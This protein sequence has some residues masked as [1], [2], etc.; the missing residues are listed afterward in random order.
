MNGPTFIGIG[1][2]KCASTWLA[3]CLARHPDIFVHPKKEIKYFNEK[4]QDFA[5]NTNFD[6]PAQWY[7]SHFEG[8]DRFTARGEF[9]PD[10]LTSESAPQRIHQMLGEVKILCIV[11]NPVDRLRSH[12][13]HCIRRGLLKAP[14][15]NLVTKNN[16]IDAIDEYPGL[17]IN[18]HYAQGLHRYIE[19]FGRKSIHVSVYERIIPAPQQGLCEIFNHLGV[20]S[21]YNCHDSEK[22]VG[23]GYI[24]RSALLEQIR[25]RIYRVVSRR[26]PSVLPLL[27]ATRLTDL[28]KKLNGKNSKIELTPEAVDYLHD[29][30]R[31]S[32]RQLEQILGYSL[33]E[34]SHGQIS[35]QRSA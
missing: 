1:G 8:T 2:Q 7:L 31:D 13:R 3:S 22:V 33:P 20:S 19:T 27:R 28:Y 4:T 26:A 10:Y 21:D 30:Y 24:P 17:I 35:Y 32:N 34:W 18:G 23:A 9:T 12:I 25:I 11:R 5:P 6:Q 29:I 16:L 15:N 14:P